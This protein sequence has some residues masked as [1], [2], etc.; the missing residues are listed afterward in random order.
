MPWCPGGLEPHGA[1][2]CPLSLFPVA[3][4]LPGAR[5]WARRALP[6][7][8]ASPRCGHVEAAGAGGSVGAEPRGL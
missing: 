8:L 7:S 3:A 5:L 4:F 6:S 1:A 2:R